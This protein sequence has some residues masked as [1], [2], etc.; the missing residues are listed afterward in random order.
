MN[1]KHGM[2]GT[3]EYNVY[4]NMMTRCYN[5]NNPNYPRYGERGI[6]VC[7]RWRDSF[8]DFYKD[9]GKRPEKMSIERTDNNGNYCP[10]NCTL[11]TKKFQSWNTRRT[12]KVKDGLEIVPLGEWA[13]RNKI[14]YTLVRYWMRKYNMSVENA[15]RKTLESRQRAITAMSSYQSNT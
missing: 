9:M 14:D 12:I 1:K 15:M 4:R 5:K 11:V 8:E 3:V 7:D 10:E 6:K 2:C 13:R